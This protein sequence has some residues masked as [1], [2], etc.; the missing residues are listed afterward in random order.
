MFDES[1]KHAR[2][3]YFSPVFFSFLFDLTK[4]SEKYLYYGGRDTYI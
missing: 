1:I 3:I 2:V 4:Q